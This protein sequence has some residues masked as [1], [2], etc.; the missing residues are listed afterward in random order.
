MGVYLSM[1]QITAMMAG[2]VIEILVKVGDSVNDGMPVAVLESMKM[3]LPVPASTAGIVK[4]I[5]VKAGA[6]VNEGEPI[7]LLE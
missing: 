7:L 4:E 3:Q 5:V 1:K 2:V 6:F